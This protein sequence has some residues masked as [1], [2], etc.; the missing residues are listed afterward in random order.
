MGRLWQAAATVQTVVQPG[1]VESAVAAGL[2]GVF[3][4]FETLSSKQ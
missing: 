3:V 2:R 4:A 1:L